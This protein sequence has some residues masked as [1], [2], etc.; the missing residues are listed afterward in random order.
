VV[1]QIAGVPR[2]GVTVEVIGRAHDGHCH[3]A[4]QWHGD[5]VL[6]DAFS[7]SNAGVEALFDDIDI[8]LVVGDLD[9]DVRMGFQEP[10]QQ[11]LQGHGHGDACRVDAQ[12][13][14]GPALQRMQL[15]AGF[16]HLTQ[17]RS[18]SRQI[19]LASLCEAD[20]ARGP[21]Q[22]PHS[23]PRFQLTD[24][25][26]ERGGRHLERSGSGGEAAV[27]RDLPEGE[28]AV[29]LVQS[30]VLKN[31]FMGYSVFRHFSFQ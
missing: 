27:L 9:L 12:H 29:E 18:N 20:A 2:G 8:A 14:R 24:R 17:R 7:Q 22:Q 4:A 15:L 6:L 10:R 23:E 30:H 31:I 16:L 21:V 3:R 13:P 5:H 25:L 19:S 26:A 1:D 28:Q 11:R